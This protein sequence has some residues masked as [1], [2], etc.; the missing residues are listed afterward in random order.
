M[1]SPTRIIATACAMAACSAA[2]P[3]KP[4]PATSAA[5]TAAPSPARA[6]LRYEGTGQLEGHF[7][8][9]G[10]VRPFSVALDLVIEGPLRQIVM[11]TWTSPDDSEGDREVTWIDSD[12]GTVVRERG[13]SSAPHFVALSGLEALWARQLAMLGAEQAVRP[14]AHPNLGDVHER[15]VPGATS[16]IDGVDAPS[17]LDL[18]HHSIE[19]SWTASLRRVPAGTTAPATKWPPPEAAAL[20]PAPPPRLQLEPVAPGVFL[21]SVP[22]SDTASLIVEL[23]DGLFVAET[24]LTTALGEQLVD[25]LAT[26]F[27]GKP[28][29]YVSFSHYHPHYTGGLRAFVAAGAEVLAPPGLAAY[30]RAVLAR[31]FTLAP[32]RLARAPRAAKVQPFTASTVV[33]APNGRRIELWDLGAASNHT[34]E[35]VVAYVPH[36]KLLFQG[37]LGWF[38]TDDG[39]VRSGRR[40]SGM[41]E[42]LR[43]RAV[44][45][46]RVAQGWPLM[47]GKQVLTRQ[48]LEAAVA[49]RR[50]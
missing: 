18:A 6:T 25:E 14:V 35:Y 13:D 24:T 27:P 49:A 19:L 11:T 47:P 5:P 16:L 7:R 3:I 23:D 43:A 1:R 34:D 50:P 26:H 41:L 15:V 32:D 10:E 22:E 17:S 45:I 39:G 2:Q 28:I 48:E 42:A 37:D 4:V 33:G 31:R 8:V 30:A 36:A 40:A 38:Q 9:P 29:R 44:P 46:E 20:P 21:A 12:K